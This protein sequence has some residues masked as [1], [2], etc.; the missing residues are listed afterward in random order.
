MNPFAANISRLTPDARQA[1]LLNRTWQDKSPASKADAGL[2]YETR[3]FLQSRASSKV[4]RVKGKE[5]SV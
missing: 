4:R 3:L 2:C 5:Q 1:G